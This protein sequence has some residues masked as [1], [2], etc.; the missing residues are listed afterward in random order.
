MSLIDIL[1]YQYE[2][3]RRQL[4]VINEK[5]YDLEYQEFLIRRQIENYLFELDEQELEKNYIP[6]DLDIIKF[7]DLNKL[8]LRIIN[9]LTIKNYGIDLNQLPRSTEFTDFTPKEYKEIV[10]NRMQ[11]DSCRYC[12]QINHTKKQCPLLEHKYCERCNENG[13]D[14][15]HCLRTK[16]KKK[17]CQRCN[18]YGH[19]IYGCPKNTNTK[20]KIRKLHNLL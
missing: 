8:P 17:F 19:N 10:I 5:K 11:L 4:R 15:Y 16:D 13:H 14:M 9:E 7:Q 3:I 12:H 20:S 1:Q 18:E 2:E 6:L